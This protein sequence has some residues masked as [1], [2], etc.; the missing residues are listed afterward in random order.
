MLNS[1][2][3]NIPKALGSPEIY[4]INDNNFI[5][6]QLFQKRGDVFYDISFYNN[7]KEI[8]IGRFNKEL[9]NLKFS[10]NNE[11][12]LLFYETF[13]SKKNKMDIIKVV[14]LYDVLDDTFIATTEEEA[15]NIFDSNLDTA[16]LIDRDNFIF[17]SDIE[18]KKKL[19]KL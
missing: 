7:G 16:Y 11:K 3:I 9:Y 8:F 15:L 10:Y 17:N 6:S 18:K 2:D 4:K 14:S 13:N 19:K 5:K 12:I 1:F